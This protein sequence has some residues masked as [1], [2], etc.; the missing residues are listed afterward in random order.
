[1]R[2]NHK[3]QVRAKVLPPSVAGIMVL[4]VSMV[5]CYWFMDSKC[6]QLGQEIRKHEQK[7]SALENERVREEARWNGKK[8]PEKLE[9]ALLQHGVAMAYPTAEQ[10]VRMDAATGSP[11]PGQ[12]SVVRFQRNRNAGERV[13]KTGQ[14]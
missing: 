6:G 4:S 13:A 7:F 3:R 9:Q 14:K 2:R 11:A 10:V 5:L 8:T 1:M 12:L